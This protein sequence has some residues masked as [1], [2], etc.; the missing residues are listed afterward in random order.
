[1]N[2]RKLKKLFEL[3]RGEAPPTPLEG[4]DARVMLAVRR[5][6]RAQVASLWEQ[7][8]QLFP[9]LAVATALIVGTCAL[10]DFVYSSQHPTE[11]PADT[12]EL[13]EQ[14]LYTGNL[15]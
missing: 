3:S 8:D 11:I 1:M 6:Q 13:A 12:T 2:D 9:R 7:L 5:E 15:E 14:W 4:F 10:A